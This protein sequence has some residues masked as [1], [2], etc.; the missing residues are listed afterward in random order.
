[1]PRPRRNGPHLLSDPNPQPMSPGRLGIMQSDHE[2]A[3]VLY[4]EPNLFLMAGVC[5]W[6]V[7]R[8]AFQ[9]IPS[10]L[11]SGLF[12]RQGMRNK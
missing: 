8:A 11:P 7:V 10:F 1:M 12:F 4:A 6:Y 3:H 5:V 2:R 9:Q